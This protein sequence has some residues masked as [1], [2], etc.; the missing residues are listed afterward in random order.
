M[1]STLTITKK[2]F[3]THINSLKLLFSCWRWLCHQLSW[4]RCRLLAF[5]YW[6]LWLVDAKPAF[7][8]PW[9]SSIFYLFCK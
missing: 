7:A 3:K 6:R 5:T 4:L 8:H 9:P 2:Y 1:K